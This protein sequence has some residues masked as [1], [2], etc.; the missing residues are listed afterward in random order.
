MQSKFRQAFTHHNVYLFILYS[1]IQLHVCTVRQSA[2]EVLG[3]ITCDFT[4]LLRADDYSVKYGPTTRSSTGKYELQE[5]DFL[6]AKC[7]NDHWTRLVP[8]YH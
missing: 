5:S 2:I 8:T 7:W 4:E 6:Y 1:A 3:R